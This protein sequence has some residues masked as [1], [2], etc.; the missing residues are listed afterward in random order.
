M[1][2]QDLDAK[3]DNKDTIIQILHELYQQFIV[4]QGKK[5]LVLVAD[6]KLYEIL[7]SLKFKYGKELNWVQ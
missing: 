2:L 7:Q 5:Y 4:G 6:A 3:S 1:Y